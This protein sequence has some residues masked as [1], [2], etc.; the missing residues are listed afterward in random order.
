MAI[1]R[2]EPD[3]QATQPDSYSIPRGTVLRSNLRPGERT[4]CE[5]RTAHDVQLW[6]LRLN[7]A[8]Y[9]TRDVSQLDLPE[10]LARSRRFPVPVADCRRDSAKDN[11][12][13]SAAVLSSRSR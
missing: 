11:Q 5:Y 6:P 1:V 9:Y 12:A 10:S 2:F 4:A 8:R 13:G 7:E 3:Y